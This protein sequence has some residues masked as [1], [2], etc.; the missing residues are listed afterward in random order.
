[1]QQ[2]SQSDFDEVVELAVKQYQ[3]SV[4]HEIRE[5]KPDVIRQ[6]LE[7]CMSQGVVLVEKVDDKIVGF[8]A[9]ILLNHH[10]IIG[11]CRLAAE[12]GLFVER[13]Q[14]NKGIAKSLNEKFEEWCSNVGVTHSMTSAMFNENFEQVKS[15]Y[16]KRGYKM[17]E[18]SFIKEIS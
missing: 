7:A 10:P 14:R 18:A 16:E 15:L 2:F 5:V 6:S 12:I 17:V 4:F 11:E 8:I 3:D 9:A 1:M 13:D